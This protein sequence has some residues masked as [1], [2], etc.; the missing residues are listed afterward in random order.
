[1]RTAQN[2]LP[3]IVDTNWKS[4]GENANELLSYSNNTKLINGTSECLH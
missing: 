1:M 2:M 4:K 3:E